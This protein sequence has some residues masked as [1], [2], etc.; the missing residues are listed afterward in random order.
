[1]FDD[2]TRPAALAA[3]GARSLTAGVPTVGYAITHLRPHRDQAPLLTD[4]KELGLP[5]AEEDLFLAVMGT[6]FSVQTWRAVS[7]TTFGA[8]HSFLHDVPWALNGESTGVA[9]THTAALAHNPSFLYD[10]RRSVEI[11]LTLDESSVFPTFRDSLMMTL[12]LRQLAW[13]ATEKAKAPILFLQS[14]VAFHNDPSGSIR[15]DGSG[16][17]PRSPFGLAVRMSV[18]L[19]DGEAAQRTALITELTRFASESGM[20]LQ[21]TD[22]R[23]GRGRGEWW[24]LVSP[25]GAKYKAETQKVTRRVLNVSPKIPGL[26]PDRAVDK[27]Y[28]MTFVGPARIGSTLAIVSNLLARNVGIIAAAVSALQELAFINLL[29]PLSP[30]KASTNYRHTVSGAFDSIGRIARTAALTPQQGAHRAELG[31]ANADDYIAVTSGPSELTP[32]NDRGS[33][34][35]A[36]WIVWEHLRG[37]GKLDPVD[38]VRTHMQRLSHVERCSVVYRRSRLL[39][40]DHIRGRAK[41]CI[42]FDDNDLKPSAAAEELSRLCVEAEARVSE[43]LRE[44]FRDRFIGL[45][46]AWREK[47]LNQWQVAPL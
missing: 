40:S 18:G 38:A 25:D 42:R 8:P 21:T 39:P 17:E 46:V 36:I 3:L 22:R 30:A 29:L 6:A 14:P 28:I 34:S 24:T 1:M 5:K 31:I 12:A 35:Y 23:F 43:A 13:A 19:A 4:Q 32:D 47:W 20:G 27:A 16:E 15:A 41:F 10:S 9:V 37:A 44:K 45:G 2:R 7:G 26:V 11:L 33:S